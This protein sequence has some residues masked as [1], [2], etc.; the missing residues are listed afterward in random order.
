MEPTEISQVPVAETAD[1]TALL[2]VAAEDAQNTFPI[3]P[4]EAAQAIFAGI[5]RQRVLYLYPQRV[6]ASV[7][8]YFMQSTLKPLTE[9]CSSNG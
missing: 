5:A 4:L 2:E 8:G 1:P 7:R 6:Q 3:S 9:Q